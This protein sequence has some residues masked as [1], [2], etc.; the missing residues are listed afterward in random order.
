MMK[1]VSLL[2][3]CTLTSA[4]IKTAEQV[5]R[6]KRF[7]NMSQQIGDTQG[8]MA[9]LVAQVK[10]MQSQLD[11]M[12]GRLEEVEHRQKQLNPEQIQK[13]TESTELLK[14][15]SDTQSTQLQ[16]IQSELK[17][18]RA[19]IEKVTASL[20]GQKDRPVKQDKKKTPA[21]N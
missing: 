13:L 6:E 5:Q 19:F 9:D 1:F 18:Q 4:C 21:R 7:E 2:I 3:F 20:A 8:L 10:D 16:Q 14:S 11:K 17:E 15:Q 12:N